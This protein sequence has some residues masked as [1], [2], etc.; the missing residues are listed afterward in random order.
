MLLPLERI[1]SELIRCEQICSG[2]A[3][4]DPVSPSNGFEVVTAL[5]HDRLK[6]H[7]VRLKLKRCLRSTSKFFTE[8]NFILAGNRSKFSKKILDVQKMNQ[9]LS[10]RLLKNNS[11]L[12]LFNLNLQ[13]V[14][15]TSN[16][17]WRKNQRLSPCD[18]VYNVLFLSPDISGSMSQ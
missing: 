7:R 17:Y 15:L 6:S 5:T 18:L 13:L 2:R 3:L 4:K 1:S 8:K 14:N 11:L 12:C 10:R 16:V 9:I